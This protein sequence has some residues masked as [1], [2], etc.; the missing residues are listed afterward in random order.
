MPTYASAAYECALA[1]SPQT[2]REVRATFYSRLSQYCP[3]GPG[4]VPPALHARFPL[5]PT[6]GVRSLVIHQFPTLGFDP[7]GDSIHDKSEKMATPWLTD[8][9]VGGR[10]RW[11]LDIVE[12]CSDQWAEAAMVGCK[13][14]VL[15]S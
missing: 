6:S 4:G 3:H 11:S 10:L 8:A 5:V 14:S 9:G 1:H 7:Q 12:S 15:Q 2:T 13:K